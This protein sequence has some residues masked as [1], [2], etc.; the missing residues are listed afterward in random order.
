MPNLTA[1]I[2]IDSDNGIRE[3]YK[4]SVS[5][6]SSELEA[7][8][9]LRRVVDRYMEELLPDDVTVIES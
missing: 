6:A 3:K 8:L 7:W 2:T 4:V 1:D 5:L 9:Q